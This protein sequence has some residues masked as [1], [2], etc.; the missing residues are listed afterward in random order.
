V[1]PAAFQEI[2]AEALA[3]AG[4]PARLLAVRGAGP[5]HPVPPAF[6]EGRYLKLLLLA[7]S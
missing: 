4:R 7:A 1:T 6:P 2:V 5:D 3:Q